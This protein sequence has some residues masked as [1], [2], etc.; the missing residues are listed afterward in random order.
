MSYQPAKRERT[1]AVVILAGLAVIA[2]L[3]SFLDA[4][5]YMGWLPIA[6]FGDMNFVLPNA[7]WFAAIMAGIVGI[8]FLVV[9]SWL[10][11]LNPSGWLFV[12]VITIFNLIFL[13]L[14][15]LGQTS[16]GDVMWQIIVNAV[17]LILALIPSTK[18]AFMPPPPSP[19]QVKA[20]T[21]AV[22][23]RRA[24]VATRA[25]VAAAAAADRTADAADRAAD[26]AG[27]AADAAADAVGGAADAAADAAGDAADAA[28]DAADAAGDAA[29]AAAGA[30]GD[31]AES[32]GET[33]SEAFTRSTGV[34][35]TDDQIAE[36]NSMSLTEIEGIGPKISAALNAAGINSFLELAITPVDDLRKI[37][38]DAGMRADPST[39]PEQ[40]TL[41]ASGRWD[42]LR[43]L[44]ENLTGG[45]RA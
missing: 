1:F 13:F 18:Q 37:L 22:A 35:L 24:D 43:S 21:D 38:A 31:A 36:I 11:N 2:G 14:A 23:D 5:R 3:L 44:Q 39:W 19:E 6:T 45:R 30:V 25:S 28:G 32:T 34:T 42:E 7:S 33:V 20:A 26:A 10:W 8:I 16:F 4:A 9:A 17:A 41:A 12:V 15:L 27:D 40:A 29:A